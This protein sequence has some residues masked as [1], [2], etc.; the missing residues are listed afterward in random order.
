[1]QNYPV[2]NS[3]TLIMAYLSNLC[4]QFY[5]LSCIII[6]ALLRALAQGGMCGT[7]KAQSRKLQAAHG[8]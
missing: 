8:G 6:E 2:Q 4:N 5:F 1:M 3:V 7:G